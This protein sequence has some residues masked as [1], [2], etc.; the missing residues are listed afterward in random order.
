M[1]SEKTEKRYENRRA[2]VSPRLPSMRSFAVNYYFL[3]FS[4][5]KMILTIM[6]LCNLFM[7]FSVQ[8]SSGFE[9]YE[10]ILSRAPFGEEPPPSETAQPERPAGEFA[11]QYRL[12]MLYEDVHG[13]LKAGL[14]S[15]TNNKNFFLQVG[16]S[17]ENLELVE[18]RLEEGLAILRQ[19]GE[20]A[21]LILEGLG[22]PMMPL[23][24]REAVAA[25]VSPVDSGVI[26]H[27]RRSG[28]DSAPE[29]IQMALTD[30]TPKQAHLTIRKIPLQIANGD[31]PEL[32]DPSGLN[33]TLISNGKSPA[34]PK[35]S[36]AVRAPVKGNYLVQSVPNRYNPF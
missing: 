30:S 16:Q 22:T 1:K 33:D 15:K 26:T 3:P 20:S 11:K 2:Q 14:V 27:V 8:A 12:C 35:K 23:S 19:G 17:D 21:Q 29:H 5:L 24:Q 4:H 31:S 10:V 28:G 9:H 6:I 34:P 13:Q 18:V 7:G 32:N 25:A 36:V